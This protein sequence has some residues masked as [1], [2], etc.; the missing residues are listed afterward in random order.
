MVI[1]PWEPLVYSSSPAASRTRER[2]ELIDRSVDWERFD[3]FFRWLDTAPAGERSHRPLTL[4]KALLLEQWFSLC[5]AEFEFDLA[6]R[7]S[8]R[9]FVGLTDRSAVPTHA[10]VCA[11]RRLLIDR[12]VAADLFAELSRQLS[13]RGIASGDPDWNCLAD[14]A[15]DLVD[16]NVDVRPQAWVE[17]ERQL[18]EYWHARRGELDVPAVGDIRLDDLPEPIKPYLLVTRVLPDGGFLHESIGVEVEAANQGKIVG[19]TIEE[20]VQRNLDE[21]GHGGMQSHLGE[22]YRDVV[23]RRRAIEA[24]TYYF[25]AQRNKCQLWMVQAPLCNAAGDIVMLIGVS[26][27]LP[28]SVN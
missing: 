25:N 7:V 6:D 3:K 26:L 13:G 20:R 15:G 5:A 9:R 14:V 4:F 10:A 1:Q 8:Y 16:F 28:V 22:L 24:S 12:G 11:F 27:I 18:L 21:F 17:M 19:S 2:L 23:A